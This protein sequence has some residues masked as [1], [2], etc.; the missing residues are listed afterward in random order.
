MVLSLALPAIPSRGN[1]FLNFILLFLNIN[2]NT[3][4]LI[5]FKSIEKNFSQ[6]SV[7]NTLVR[8]LFLIGVKNTL[9]R[10]LAYTSVHA[11]VY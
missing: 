6:G 3:M 9:V 11:L 7:K 10:G 4:I 8:G 2:I 5:C 1:I